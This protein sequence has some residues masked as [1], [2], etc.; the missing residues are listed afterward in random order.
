MQHSPFGLLD[1]GLALRV[2]DYAHP[3]EVLQDAG[4]SPAQKRVILSAWASDA[5]AVE[6]RPAF[7]WMPGTPGPVAFD[8]IQRAV[9][10][11]DWI[12]D[13]VPGVFQCPQTE[14]RHPMPG[15]RHKH[16]KGS[17]ERRPSCNP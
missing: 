1:G 10:I 4:L 5:C 7:R 12:V 6:S 16:G 8:H 15:N 9:A 13:Q 11:L 14:R 17:E 3:T 2:A